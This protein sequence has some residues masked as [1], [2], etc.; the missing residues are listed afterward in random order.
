MVPLLVQRPKWFKSARDL[1]VGDL[2]L[3][4]KQDNVLSNKWTVVMSKDGLI[5]RAKVR[6][7]NASEDKIRFTDRAVRS[8]SFQLRT[9]IC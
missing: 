9:I 6:Y 7:Y 2:V 4:K 5:R 3:F 1:K 8:K